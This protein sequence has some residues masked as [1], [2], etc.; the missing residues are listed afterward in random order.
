MPL[1][2]TGQKADAHAGGDGLNLGSARAATA[3]HTQN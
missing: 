3:V 2:I 1:D